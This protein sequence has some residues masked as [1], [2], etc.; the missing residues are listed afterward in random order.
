[1]HCLELG[2]V[3]RSSAYGELRRSH[4]SSPLGTRQMKSM[5]KSKCILEGACRTPSS[6]FAPKSTG[7]CRYFASTILLI[8]RPYVTL[9][10]SAFVLG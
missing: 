2:V 3:S 10:T 4:V 9:H 7:H 1:M 5:T 6:P 8:L